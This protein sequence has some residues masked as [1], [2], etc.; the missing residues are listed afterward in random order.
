MSPSIR[1]R[2]TFADKRFLPAMKNSV[3]VPMSVLVD[4]NFS[5]VRREETAG[6]LAAI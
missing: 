5:L 3:P 1:R 4:V 2:C 6:G